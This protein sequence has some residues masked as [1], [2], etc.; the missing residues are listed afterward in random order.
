MYNL[1]LKLWSTNTDQYLKEAK[2]LYQEGIYSYIELYVYPDTT[3][4]IKQWVELKNTTTIPF[5]LHAPHFT[6]GVN[7]AKAEYEDFNI[8][9]YNQ[10]KEF[11]KELD[12]KYVV[13][14][15]GTEG[16][17]EEAIRQLNL[18]KLEKMLIENKP[19]K[20]PLAKGLLCRGAEIGEIQQVLQNVDCGFCLDVGHAICT[21]NTLKKKPYEYLK[22]FNE[23]KP[24]C[25]HLSDNLINNEIDSHMH[26]GDGN[27]D[28]KKIFDIIDTSKNIAVETNKNSNDSLDDFK[29]DVEQINQING[30]QK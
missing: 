8:K 17:I 28:F 30:R 4:S 26:I 9:I 5:T 16:S 7:L 6:H 13:V 1:G 18:I 14:H 10:V 27:Y 15:A 3:D 29:G 25:Y 19:Y 11:S 12:A 20:A 24:K 21:A 2:K 23:L 22:E